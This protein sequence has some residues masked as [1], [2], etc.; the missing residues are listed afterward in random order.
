MGVFFTN[1]FAIGT[2]PKPMNVNVHDWVIY[3]DTYVPAYGNGQITMPDH[4]NLV[5]L[6][7]LNLV[8]NDP[9]Y[10]LYINI[11]NLAG[12]E[13][14]GNLIGLVG[15]HT[16]LSFTWG[17][18]DYVTFNCTEDAFRLVDIGGGVLNVIY[19]QTYISNPSA[20]NSISVIASSNTSY[21]AGEPI[22]I[23]YTIITNT[24]NVYSPRFGQWLL[25]SGPSG[26]Q[27]ASTNGV[28]TLPVFP[29]N[30]GDDNPNDVTNGPVGIYINALD[31][32]GNTPYILENLLNQSGTLSLTQGSNHITY[33]Y[34]SGSFQSATYAGEGQVYWDYN[35]GPLTIISSSNTVFNGYT[36]GDGNVGSLTYTGSSIGPNNVQLV[37]IVIHTDA[38]FTV[39]TSMISNLMVAGNYIH[40]SPNGTSGF[41][42]SQAINN[43]AHGVY[44]PTINNSSI[45]TAFANAN[46]P[47]ND[48]T[49]YIC[50]V[51][52]GP[53]STVP[54]GFAKVA[55]VAD[56]GYITIGSVDPS[57]TNLGN[58]DNQDDGTSLAGTFNFPATFTL[59]RPTDAK[60]GWC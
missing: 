35:A 57:D 34:S 45:T 33:A 50:S 43:L 9:N 54:R 51:E 20:A 37:D 14:R 38:T 49:G 10:S 21:T 36:N 40:G 53:G 47:T 46:I 24:N 55:Y 8:P 26:F 22:K 58:N 6:T 12:F 18:S 27:P 56:T 39:E 4:T 5:N 30:T 28:L 3:S 2:N 25:M 60:G 7:D 13:Q 23:A 29:A 15:N 11:H 41:T 19:D 44:G 1:G 52:W 42:V 59:L 48:N 16:H 17:T 31:A 32:A